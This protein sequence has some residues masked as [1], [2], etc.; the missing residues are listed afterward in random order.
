MISHTLIVLSP[1]PETR[2][3]PSVLM[4]TALTEPECKLRVHNNVP[5]A[6]FFTL[7]VLSLL[8]ETKIFPSGLIANELKSKFF[9]SLPRL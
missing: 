6:K 8:R 2:V 9:E 1:L 7:I 5:V 3:F 4:A